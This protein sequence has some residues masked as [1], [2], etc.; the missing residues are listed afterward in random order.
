MIV[1]NYS[2]N[3]GRRVS[4]WDRLEV[5]GFLGV[6]CDAEV[7]GDIRLLN[8]DCAEDFDIAELMLRNRR[9]SNVSKK[10]GTWPNGRTS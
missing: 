8:A 6:S 3:L 2:A 9:R 4:V 10:K 7:T 1:G 5:N